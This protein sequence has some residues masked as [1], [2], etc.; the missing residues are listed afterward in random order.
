M[1]RILSFFISLLMLIFCAILIYYLATLQ[2][3]VMKNI[4]NDIKNLTNKTMNDEDN[5]D[6]DID[7]KNNGLNINSNDDDN[8][9]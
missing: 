7:N 3:S 5:D 2:A 6:D 1:R 8:N 4:Q 9:N